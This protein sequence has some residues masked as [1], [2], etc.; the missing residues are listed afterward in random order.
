MLGFCVCTFIPSRTG[1][2]QEAG[3]PRM[4]S[5]STAHKRHEPKASKLSLAH[6]LGILI[7]AIAAA[8]NTEVPSGTTISTPSICTLTCSVDL[9]GGVPRSLLRST[10]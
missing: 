8:R 6:N 10:G 2:V 9:E 1:V 3:M 4:P 5:I 7:S